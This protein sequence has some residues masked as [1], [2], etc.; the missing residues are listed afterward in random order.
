MFTWLRLP[1]QDRLLKG[2]LPMNHVISALKG[3][4]PHV[5]D[6]MDIIL[7]RKLFP[8][9]DDIFPNLDKIYKAIYFKYP[10]TVFRSDCEIE[11]HRELSDLSV[12]SSLLAD[13]SVVS[14]PYLHL[15]RH[16]DTPSSEE[17]GC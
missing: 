8:V 4:S 6:L 17:T 13:T 5:D 12:Y 10:N 15:D 14:Y 11:V 1:T 16:P 9:K 2:T 7:G 3:V